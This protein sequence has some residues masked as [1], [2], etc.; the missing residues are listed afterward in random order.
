M[1]AQAIATANLWL[2]GEDWSWPDAGSELGPPAWVSA[3]PGGGTVAFAGEPFALSGDIVLGGAAELADIEPTEP[4]PQITATSLRAPVAHPAPAAVA[5]RFTIVPPDPAA[6]PRPRRRPSRWRV[7]RQRVIACVALLLVFGST[8]E[9]AA[10]LRSSGGSSHA[11]RNGAHAAGVHTAAVAP[12]LAAS[13]PVPGPLASS[14]ATLSIL[15]RD[16]SG[17]SIARVR[18]SSLALHRRASFLVYLPPGYTAGTAH[19]YP[20]LYLLHGDNQL[21]NAY[22]QVGLPSTLDQ[23]IRGGEVHPLIAVILEGARRTDNWRNDGSTRYEDYVVETQQL[24]DRMLPTVANRGGRA[25][26]GLSMGG[27]GA[28]NVALGHL[29]RYSVVESWLGFFNHL[30]PELKADASQFQHLP[31]TAFVYGAA[32]DSIAD[33]SENAPFA[34]ALR[35]AGASA[36]SAVYP[37]GHTLATIQAHLRDTI[38]LAGRALSPGS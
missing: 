8:F 5:R 35:A 4:V 24:V 13:P 17:S 34:A 31:L 25:I 20:V 32:S 11:A 36:S 38:V 27:F 10:H 15:S 3:V 33:P 22:L 2:D 7:A 26:A 12:A 14:H 29:D 37:G 1:A 6:A 16:A 23:V 30:G 9:L 21:G 19:R 28:M 18:Y